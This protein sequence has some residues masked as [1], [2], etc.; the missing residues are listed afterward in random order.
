MRFLFA[1]I[2]SFESDFYGRVGEELVRRGHEVG[3]V[4]YSRRS[5][6]RLS[7]RGL[8]AHS[9]RALLDEHLVEDVEAESARVVA[10]YGI[11]SLRD[12]YR[13][14]GPSAA[15]GDGWSQRRTVAHFRVL[16]HLFDELQ[17]D[18]L[19]PEVGTEL[20][21]AV[22]HRIALRR[23]VPTLFLFYT[24]FPKPLRLY[25][26]TMQAPIVPESELR[27]LSS[28]ELDELERFRADF[29]QRAR[30]IRAHR[31]LAPTVSR[32]RGAAEYVTARVVED[33]D[34]EYLRPGRWARQHAAAW[35]RAAAAATLYREP[36]T[37]PFVYFPLH[38]A[39][40]YKIV[41]L[42]PQWADQAALVA[43]VAAALPPGLDLVI[44]EHPLSLGRNELA[45]LRRLA[46]I[47]RVRLVHPTTSSHAL[48]RDCAG[49]V[50]I[51]STV[52]LEALLYEKPVLTLGRPFYS[53]YGLTIDVDSI[54]ELRTALPRL[55]AFRPDP[56]RTRR[57]LH[58][59]WR[60]CYAGAPVLV[61]RSPENAVLLASSL[62]EAASR[63][64]TRGS[65][66][67][68]ALVH[69]RS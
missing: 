33:R 23:G 7:E 45:V 22:A 28:R 27:P 30:P 26:D 35:G 14:D 11:S 18:V 4:T 55:P 19:V 49:V 20:M 47:E 31:T 52:G 66:V 67:R 13:T 17:P 2:Q 1:T 9:V 64:R 48:L 21:R 53:G 68:D 44:K 54:E 6:R 36:P 50:V 41:G 10:H 62:D 16:E 60:S 63:L 61:D 43:Q 32:V 59:A 46:R 57:F 38:V 34:N 56:E 69:A 15:H 40:D 5:A 58:A 12:V 39:D 42:I 37:A 25:V 3:H 24:I 29:T 51:S 65:T 8:S